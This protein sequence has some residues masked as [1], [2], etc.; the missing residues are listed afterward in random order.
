MM[1][2]GGARSLVRRFRM[3]AGGA[4]SIVRRFRMWARSGARRAGEASNPRSIGPAGGST[5][6][7]RP[8]STS[9]AG[10]SP[11]SGQGCSVSM[12]AMTT[13][14]E[15][16][17]AAT[18]AA[19]RYIDAERDSRAAPARDVRLPEALDSDFLASP[20]SAGAVLDLLAEAGDAGTTRSTGGRYFGFVTG[21]VEPIALAA[22]TLAGAWDQNAALPVMSPIASK[23]DE[24]AARWVVELLELPSESVASFCAGATV[25]NLT[26]VIAGRDE[27]LA[28]AGWDV[29]SRGL[30]GSPPITVVTGDEV[31]ASALKALQLA[32]F[33]SDQIIRVSTDELR[34]HS[35]RVVA[36]HRRS[37]A[38]RAAGRQRQHGA[39]RPVRRH[40]PPTRSPADVGARR[41][42]LRVVGQAGSGAPP[43]RR[44]R[45]GRRLVG[46]RR[47]QVAQRSVRLRRDRV[48]RR[49]HL[50]AGDDHERRLRG[51]HCRTD[52]DEPRHPDV[53]SGTGGPRL[54]D[55]GDART[56]R[57]RRDHRTNL[58]T[59]RA[60]GGAP[61]R[62]WRRDPRSRRTQSGPGLASEAT[63]RPTP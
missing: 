41:R 52:T 16:M 58:R 15:L 2:A 12:A 45:R 63:P 36:H 39:Q 49:C 32:G 53:A 44:R 3:W 9:S 20:W 27:L 11:R 54:G 35:T 51:E 4:R 17:Q 31:H 30:A 48:P 21:G 43:H 26:G 40:H 46:D 13:K 14:P 23:L 7:P 60:D 50:V 47:P 34:P 6:P 28:R 25:A 24:I 33:G 61:R 5:A 19:I 1:W 56:R 10:E 55:S 8:M 18:D 38:G 62:R 22:S 42:C 29:H 59:R 57:R 37:D